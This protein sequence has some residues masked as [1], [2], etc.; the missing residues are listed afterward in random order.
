MAW[1]CDGCSTTATDT[2]CMKPVHY[3]RHGS[4]WRGSPLSH[5]HARTPGFRC[6]RW[7]GQELG[8]QQLH[9]N[10]PSELGGRSSHT[11]Q[12]SRCAGP[13]RRAWLPQGAPTLTTESKCVSVCLCLSVKPQS[14][15]PRL[16]GTDQTI[17]LATSSLAE[18]KSNWHLELGQASQQVQPAALEEPQ[19]KD[20][21]PLHDCDLRL[22]LPRGVQLLGCRSSRN[23]ARRV[24][25]RN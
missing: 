10:R 18:A 21:P 11:R 13:Q 9:K 3:H 4:S 5:P 20:V 17:P 14:S 1:A 15:V 22:L 24:E 2:A 16:L 25:T 23:S 6:Q 7:H 12:R 19:E 8:A